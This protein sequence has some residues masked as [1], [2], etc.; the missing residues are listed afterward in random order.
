MG[1]RAGVPQDLR[2]EGRRRRQA[3]CE[4]SP[5]LAQLREPALVLERSWESH[6]SLLGRLNRSREG[7]VWAASPACALAA[8]LSTVGWYAAGARPFFFW[9]SAKGTWGGRSSAGGGAR[10]GRFSLRMLPGQGPLALSCQRWR[11]LPVP[12]LNLLPSSRGSSV[13]KQ[14]VAHLRTQ[15]TPSHRLSPRHHDQA[16]NPL[17]DDEHAS[18]RNDRSRRRAHV[19]A[20]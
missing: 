3:R 4:H 16:P 10:R 20:L 15:L 12:S 2:V 5:F 18:S 13:S 7:C 1:P 11:A 17:Y 19:H 8:P 6:P 14:H 9:R